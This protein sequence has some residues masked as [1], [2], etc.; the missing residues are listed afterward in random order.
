MT[1]RDERDDTEREEGEYTENKKEINTHKNE[2]RGGIRRHSKAKCE[3][4]LWM[5][6]KD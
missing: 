4:I 3:E 2:K 5:K 6:G 1:N